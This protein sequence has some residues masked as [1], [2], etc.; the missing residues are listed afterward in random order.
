[1][2]IDS[3]KSEEKLP[4][5]EMQLGRTVE[6]NAAKT[7]TS[8]VLVAGAGI[9]KVPCP[10]LEPNLNLYKLQVDDEEGQFCETFSLRPGV[11]SALVKLARGD[12]D[13]VSVLK[14]VICANQVRSLC[15]SA[16]DTKK[17]ISKKLFGGKRQDLF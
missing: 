6:S 10:L 3:I 7:V 4:S 5:M 13:A 16:K 2:R 14:A 1:M 11:S 8:F 12:Y 9:D 17:G 15:I